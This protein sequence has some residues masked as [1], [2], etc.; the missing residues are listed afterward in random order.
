MAGKARNVYF[1]EDINAL[2]DKEDN[3]SKVIDDAMRD[4]YK[5][6]GLLS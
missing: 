2:L 6:N 1:A 5:K 3:M 4:Y